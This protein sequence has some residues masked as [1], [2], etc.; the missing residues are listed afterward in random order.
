MRLLWKVIKAVTLSIGLFVHA[1][2]I[3]GAGHMNILTR[4]AYLVRESGHTE[5][6]PL[7]S[8][9]IS[10]GQNSLLLAPCSAPMCHV[11]TWYACEPY[12]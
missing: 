7:L 6:A 12:I 3:D 11:R 8:E 4:H 2:M 9:S 1:Y 10:H 5:H